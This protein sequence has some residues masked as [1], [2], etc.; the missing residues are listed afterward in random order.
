MLAFDFRQP[1][2]QQC[3]PFTALDRNVWLG[4]VRCRRTGLD[5]ARLQTDFGASLATAAD[6]GIPRDSIKPSV[7]LTVMLEVRQVLKVF[8]EGFL[9]DLLGFVPTTYVVIHRRK[10]TIIVP[11]D[12][13]AERGLLAGEQSLDQRLVFRALR[14]HCGRYICDTIHD[15]ICG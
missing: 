3:D 2:P 9:D 6:A 14:K 15:A 12:E 5:T 4:P 13:I 8:Y 7:K 10:D 11:V 1:A